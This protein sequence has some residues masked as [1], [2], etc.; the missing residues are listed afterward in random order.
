MKI[1]PP[2]NQEPAGSLDWKGVVAAVAFIGAQFHTVTRIVAI[3]L[4]V[5]YVAVKWYR[6]FRDPERRKKGLKD[7]TVTPNDKV[8]H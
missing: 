8:I 1:V 6:R 5:T 4:L 2:R 7:S 3:L